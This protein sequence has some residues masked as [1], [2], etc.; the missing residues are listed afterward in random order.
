MGMNAEQ[1]TSAMMRYN[2]RWILEQIRNGRQIIDI[3]A[4]PNRV[5]SSIFYQMEKSMLRSYQKLHPEFRGA[6]CP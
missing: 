6:I 1:V 2:R 5:I 3:G 4:D